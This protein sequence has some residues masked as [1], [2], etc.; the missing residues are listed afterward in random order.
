MPY[1]LSFSIDP[2][3]NRHLFIL[4]NSNTK[5]DLKNVENSGD[6]IGKKAFDIYLTNILKQNKVFDHLMKS[7]LSKKVLS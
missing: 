2:T 7:F 6:C 3:S 1:E 5:K 4:N